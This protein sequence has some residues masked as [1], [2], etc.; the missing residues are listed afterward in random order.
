MSDVGTERNKMVVYGHDFCG[1][2]RILTRV[3][4]KSEIEY[5]YR[6]V[7]NGKP[8][9]QKELKKLANGNLSVPTVVFPD[10]EV[11]VEPW[12]EQVLDRLGVD[13]PGLVSRLKGL[14]S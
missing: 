10:G 9:W 4:K 12:P 13:Q 14:F 8:V 3:L 5:E 6:D 1:Q 7:V 2:S 11:L